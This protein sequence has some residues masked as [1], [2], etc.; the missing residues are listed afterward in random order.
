VGISD[1]PEAG[2]VVHRAAEPERQ[3]EEQV[4]QTSLES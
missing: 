1:R 4:R 3:L 2:L